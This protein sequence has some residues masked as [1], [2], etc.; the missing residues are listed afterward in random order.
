MTTNTNDLD[1]NNPRPSWLLSFLPFLTS[2]ETFRPVEHRSRE[3]VTFVEDVGAPPPAITA[4]ALANTRLP[5]PGAFIS[6]SF[7]PGIFS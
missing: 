2:D 4:D 7:K 6:S 3:S 1:P 5:D